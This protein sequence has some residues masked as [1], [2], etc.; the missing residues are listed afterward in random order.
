MNVYV[1]SEETRPVVPRPP[2][3]DQWLS[4][5]QGRQHLSAQTLL[6][7]ARRPRLERPPHEPHPHADSGQIA[8][9]PLPTQKDNKE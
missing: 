2:A 6:L 1:C 4:R 7:P 9:C 5:A 8:G 3:Q